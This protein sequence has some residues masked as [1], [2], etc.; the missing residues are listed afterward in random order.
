[1]LNS[2]SKLKLKA[3]AFLSGALLCVPL[4]SSTALAQ[5]TQSVIMTRSVGGP[6]ANSSMVS[7]RS[8][9]KYCDMLALSAEQRETALTMHSG[10]AAAYETREKARREA[11]EEVRRVSEDSGDQSVFMERL[12]KIDREFNESTSKLEKEF[13][14]DFKAILSE[15]AQEDAWAKV[16]RARRR[17]VGL[18]MGSLSGESVDLVE[19][20]HA[21]KLDEAAKKNLTIVL[22]S[23][24]SELDRLL[25]ARL[26]KKSD[27]NDWAPGKPLDLE[28]IQ[29]SMKTSR[30][31]GMKV[32]EVNR[33]N[34]RKIQ[35]LLPEAKRPEFETAFEKA[36]FPRVFRTPRIMKD[37][38]A[39]FKLSDLEQ[40]Q[41]TQIEE[42][43]ESYEREL[44]GANKRWAKAIEESESTG[45][46]GG[47]LG[48]PGG[49][50]TLMLGDEP[51][52]LKDARKARRELDEKTNERLRKVLTES[53]RE[54]L[55]KPSSEDEDGVGAPGRGM[56]IRRT[57]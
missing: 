3:T 41:K 12:P 46:A 21:L 50:M 1:M 5:Q 15:P 35:D 57:E 45:D 23:Y 36:S 18:R 11:I 19:L 4:L 13:F 32:R 28:K 29:E 54:K 39:A 24:E 33:E 49:R 26:A 37:M 44:T 30:E 42:I 9:E 8:L 20:V 10:Y 51:Q 55:P 31:E 38:E 56:M 2:T 17:E 52:A 48:G 16:E 14:S 34:A 6:G 47:T 43:K 27:E 7:K 40:T 53:Q 22:D 25:Q